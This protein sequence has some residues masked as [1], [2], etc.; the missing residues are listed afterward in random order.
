MCSVLRAGREAGRRDS[1][2][3]VAEGAIDR[4]GKEISS[5]YVKKV[6]EEKLGEDTRVT[7][8]GHVQRG[9]SPSAFDRNLSTLCGHE[10]V[11]A[12]ASGDVRG[13]AWMIGFVVTA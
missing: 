6:L 7:I 8:L 1:I 9:G 11:K 13:Q 5:E 2:V 12:I 10:A 4:Y 3:I